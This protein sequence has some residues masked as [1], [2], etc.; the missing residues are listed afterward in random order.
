MLLHSQTGFIYIEL[1][2]TN[3]Y[4]TTSTSINATIVFT[5][6]LKAILFV[7][8]IYVLRALFRTEPNRFRAYKF[9]CAF[10]QTIFIFMRTE[11]NAG[12]HVCSGE[13]S[14]EINKS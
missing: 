9:R 3:V 8:F 1:V 7:R 5:D 14:K 10:E 13:F 12:M 4:G 11:V 2:F 6:S